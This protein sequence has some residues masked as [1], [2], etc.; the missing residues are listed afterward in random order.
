MDTI[1]TVFPMTP[2]ENTSSLISSCFTLSQG[3]AALAV[4]LKTK[5]SKLRQLAIPAAI[6][7]LFGGTSEPALYGISV[8]MKKPL[9][10]T[11]IGSTVA[12]IYAL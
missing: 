7:G 6:S 3:A 9:Y 8:K 1:P 11:I 10:A 4:L 2:V 5:N 12:G